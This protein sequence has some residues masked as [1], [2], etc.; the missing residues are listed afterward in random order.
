[1][2][3]RVAIDLKVPQHYLRLA[4]GRRRRVALERTR[5]R[6]GCHLGIDECSARKNFVYATVFSDP[7]RGVV[8]DLAPGRDASAVMFFAHLYSHAEW[9]Q[10]VSSAVTDIH[11]QGHR[12]GKDVQNGNHGTEEAPSSSVVHPGVQS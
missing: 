8:I 6:F 5:G 2:T 7:E 9:A 1:M 12:P 11:H 4:V 10:W 3:R